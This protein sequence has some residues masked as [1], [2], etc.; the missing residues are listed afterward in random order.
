MPENQPPK[1]DPGSLHKKYPDLHTSGAV[2]MTGADMKAQPDEK[3][4]EYLGSM[5]GRHGLMGG[6]ETRKQAQIAK[7]IIGE[8]DIPESY[9]EQQRRI[10]REQGHGD[11]E[12]TKEMRE[13]MAEAVRADQTASL[14]R[15]VDY[16]NHPDANYPGW[17]RYFTIRNVLKMSDFDK[18]KGEF[19]KRSQQTTAPYPDLN[20][21]ALAYVYDTL[22]KDPKTHDDEQ[23]RKLAQGGNF[24]KLYAHAIKEVTP[25]SAE[26]KD[27]IEGSWTKFDQS[28][29]PDKAKELA[30]SLQGHGTGWCTAGES[31]AEL[32][33]RGGDFYVYYSKDE[34][35]NETIPRIAVRMENGV[36]AEVRGINPS[37][38]LESVMADTT[39][40]KLKD[41]PGGEQYV[42]KAEDMK[43]LTAIDNKLSENP[44]AE[45]SKEELTFL[46]EIDHQVEGFGYQK[47]PRIELIRSRRDN[48]SDIAVAL[49]I[50]PE[51]VSLT[52]EEALSGNAVYHYGDLDLAGLTSAEGLTLPTSVGGDL[53]LIRLTSAEGLTL[54]TSV[55]G[56]LDLRRLTSAEGLTL[57]TSV[58]GI[59]NLD[60]LTSAEGLTLPESVGG[61]LYLGNLTSAEGLTLPTS[62]GGYLDLARLTSA[63]GLTL[64]TSVGGY[65]NLAGLTSAE[66]LTLPTSVG[67]ILDL[68]NLTSAEGLTLPTSVGGD[69]DLR[70]L[71][72]AEGLTLPTSVGGHLNLTS[73]TSADREHL[74][75]LHPDLY[76]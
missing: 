22:N 54:P 74:I 62:V 60:R 3:I 9:F 6:E 31:T 61:G 44:D 36:V 42:Q 33:L 35:G 72:T 14:E 29:D 39:M 1:Q 49:D 21:E 51:Q 16:V 4:S 15:W 73:L 66:G 45:L 5:V 75:Q 63:E 7:R 11:I 58:G 13:Q 32:Q 68:R 12:I 70:N 76:I 67:G 20:R 30:T 59:L 2:E 37:Q 46:Y 57:P 23:L 18:A 71:T 64:P 25:A 8:D 10:A 47:D 24:A 41:L 65:L 56:H 19:R 28:D 48:R 27:T 26:L 52:K 69:L 53:D 34:E 40:E 55:G 38:E 17:F 50:S 43:R